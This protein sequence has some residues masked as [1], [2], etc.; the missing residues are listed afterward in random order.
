M[1]WMRKMYKEGLMGE[2]QGKVKMPINEDDDDD[3]VELVAWTKALD[4]DTYIDDWQSMA[5]T[6][7]SG[8]VADYGL[9]F[10]DDNEAFGNVRCA[11]RPSARSLTTPVSSRPQSR[12][13][14]MELIEG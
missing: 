8:D 7:N 6:A 9:A 4:F 1:D 5:T 10:L 11:R 14:H 13:G 12:V 3:D 2:R